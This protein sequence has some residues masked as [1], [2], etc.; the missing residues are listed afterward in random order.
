M[1][2]TTPGTATAGEVLT[3]AFWNTNVR[4]NLN[5][6]PRG[7]LG[8]HTST[9]A[10]QTSATHTTAQDEGLTKS[11]TYEAN[12]TLKVTLRVNPFTTGGLQAVEYQVLRG[13]TIIVVFFINL[14]DLSTTAATVKTLSHT[15][16]G[17]ASAATETFKVQYRAATSNTAVNSYADA[18]L[19]KQLVVED[20]GPA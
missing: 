1:A 19:N 6:S 7:I 10:F 8:F 20:I 12:R 11:I 14:T 16:N 13:A 17:P 15:F 9:T 3:A 4:D 2:W 18:T 5:A